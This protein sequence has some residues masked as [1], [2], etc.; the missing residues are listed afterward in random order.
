MFQS[1]FSLGS[2]IPLEKLKEGS[3]MRQFLDKYVQVNGETMGSIV[4]HPNN[5]RG[6]YLGKVYEEGTKQLSGHGILFHSFLGI[7]KLGDIFR[8]RAYYVCLS[9]DETDDPRASNDYIVTIDVALLPK[10][11]QEQAEPRFFNLQLHFPEV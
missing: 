5:L 4:V 1:H 7:K 11:A 9:C 10:A 8:E 3:L 6:T 2:N